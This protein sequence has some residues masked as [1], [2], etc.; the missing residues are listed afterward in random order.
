[1]F[2]ACLFAVILV[3]FQFSSYSSSVNERFLQ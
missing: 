2:L 3:G 1:M